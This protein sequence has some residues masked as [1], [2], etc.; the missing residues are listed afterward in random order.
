MSYYLFNRQEL[1][2]KVQDRYHNGGKKSAEYYT[3]NKEVLKKC[4]KNKYR[5]FSEE[6]KQ[7][8]R[9]IWEKQI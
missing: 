9:K 4:K 1:L 6:A 2:Q 5:N 8:K 7:T 3:G